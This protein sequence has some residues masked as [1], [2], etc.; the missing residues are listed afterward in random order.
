MRTVIRVDGRARKHPPIIFAGGLTMAKVQPIIGTMRGASGDMIITKRGVATS[1]GTYPACSTTEYRNAIAYLVRNYS[2]SCIAYK[3]LCAVRPWCGKPNSGL[4]RYAN[5]VVQMSLA[6]GYYLGPTEQDMRPHER[7]LSS[8]N[9]PVVDAKQNL[10]ASSRW[11]GDGYQIV[12]RLP[13][14]IDAYHT[15]VMYY[16]LLPTGRATTVPGVGGL[17]VPW[18]GVQCVAWPAPNQYG[19]Y[20]IDDM[21]CRQLDYCGTRPGALHASYAVRKC[22]GVLTCIEA[23]MSSSPG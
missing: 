13:F 6:G 2:P 1:H 9:R 7:Y 16:L 5:W 20:M 22:D 3:Q 4:M 8:A 10:K 15:P 14:S 12:W 18:L 23:A 17:F 19:V 11:W 21:R